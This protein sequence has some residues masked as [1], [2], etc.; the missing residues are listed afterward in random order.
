MSAASQR[1]YNERR[2]AGL[3]VHCGQSPPVPGKLLCQPHLDRLKANVAAWRE[4][5]GDQL[6]QRAARLRRLWNGGS[7]DVLA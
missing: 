2:A 6:K 1:L 5:G 3:C 7:N 4:R